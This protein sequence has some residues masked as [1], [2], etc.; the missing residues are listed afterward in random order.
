ME[1]ENLSFIEKSYVVKLR[2]NRVFYFC[3][4]EDCH[5]KKEKIL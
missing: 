2:K 1:V 5:E 3:L 4:A